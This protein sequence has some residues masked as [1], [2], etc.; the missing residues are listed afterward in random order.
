VKT[1]CTVVLLLY[2]QA[3]FAADRAVLTTTDYA[4]GS[5]SV[6][7]LATNTPTND[8]LTIHSDAVVRVH[9]GRVYIVNRFGQDNV[10]VLSGED[11]ATP[12]A[13]YSVGN[14]TNP[15]DIAILH[16]SKAY[17]SRL[18]V[19]SL[20][21]V[22][23]VT[24]DSLG[25]IDLSSFADADGN[26]EAA[27][28]AI[29]GDR[30]YVVC[31]RLDNFVPTDKSTVA[32]VDV[33]T[34]TLVD[35]DPALPGLQGIDLETKNP[36]S[37]RQLGDRWYLASAGD[38][39]D[40]ADGGIEVLDLREGATLGVAFT[41]AQLGGGLGAIAVVGRD[42]GYV[43]VADET[44]AN[45]VV[46]F[47]VARSEVGAA[48][49]GL[50]G[51]FVPDL[52]VHKGSLYILDRGSFSDPAAAGVVVVDTAT[53]TVTAGPI[54]TGL[55]PSGIAFLLDEKSADFDRSGTVDFPDFLTFAAGFGK[56]AGEAGFDADLDLDDSDAVDFGDFLLFADRFGR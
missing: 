44:F 2:A 46:P 32:V 45:H 16:Q 33:Q 17:V 29:Y 52:V 53:N 12:A 42:R 34:D 27:A 9:H 40:Y 3:S 10:L 1:I 36:F 56:A 7:D 48:V 23:P 47:D 25:S 35:A 51:G 24:G 49:S 18:G 22:N 37:A 28:M 19:A 11:P 14:G 30:L 6:L 4:T 5:L 39:T 54:A 21:V 38:F 31:Q 55:P 50:S 13:Q 41:E 15:Q 8:L 20:L 43:V 26:P